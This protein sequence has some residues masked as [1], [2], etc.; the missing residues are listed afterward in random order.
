MLSTYTHPD[1]NKGIEVNS[2]YCDDEITGDAGLLR[3]MLSNLLLNAA[4]P[5]TH[6]KRRRSCQGICGARMDGEKKVRIAGDR[7]RQW[8]WHF[9]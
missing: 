5:A 2:R 3:R 1:L 9:R 8:L 7:G 6:Q 4:D